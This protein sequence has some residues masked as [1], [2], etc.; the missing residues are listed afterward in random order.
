MCHSSSFS[1]VIGNSEN[2]SLLNSNPIEF[3][4]EAGN[5]LYMTRIL[6]DSKILDF[7]TA[8]KTSQCLSLDFKQ[9]NATV[10]TTLQLLLYIQNFKSVFSKGDFGILLGYHR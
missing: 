10:K 1:I 3:C 4:E 2:N 9:A 5:C 8:L 7:H 6:S